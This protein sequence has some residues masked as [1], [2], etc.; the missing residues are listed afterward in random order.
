MSNQRYDFGDG[1]LVPVRI[2]ENGGGIIALTAHVE[3][4]VFVSAGCRVC[5]YARLLDKV[6]VVGRVLINGGYF[7]HGVSVQIENEAMIVGSVQISGSVLV[8]DNAQI[9]DNVRLSGCVKVY[10]RARITGD[11]VMEG[12]VKVTENAY[13]TGHSRV[14]ALGRHVEILG[15]HYMNDQ[16]VEHALATEGQKKRRATALRPVIFD[17]VTM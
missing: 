15:D 10:H 16:K 8:R 13:V 1:R 14:I 11:V 3:P 9:R 17:T 7:P 2:H 4:S 12:N 6:R 5:G